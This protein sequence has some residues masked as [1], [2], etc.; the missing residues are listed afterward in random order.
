M[1][2]INCFV[3]IMALIF[4]NIKGGTDMSNQTL[5]EDLVFDVPFENHILNLWDKENNCTLIVN[6]KDITSNTAVYYAGEDRVYLPFLSILENLGGIVTWESDSYAII[7]YLDRIYELDLEKHLICDK[8]TKD[9]LFT[10]PAGGG[11]CCEIEALLEKDVIIN[12]NFLPEIFDV[13]ID[14]ENSI[15]TITALDI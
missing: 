7:E 5:Q 14:K 9:A 11:Y 10:Y 4:T 2:V 13:K 12:A 6:G 1:K 3:I 15:I 8:E